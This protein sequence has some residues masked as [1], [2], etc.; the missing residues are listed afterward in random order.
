MYGR[1]VN[2]SYVH[3]YI[4]LFYFTIHLILTEARSKCRVLPLV[5]IVK[6][7]T[8]SLLLTSGDEYIFLKI[9]PPTFISMSRVP[10]PLALFAILYIPH[11]NKEP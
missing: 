10:H 9:T 7:F 4:F 3:I 6:S 8:K 5:F 11:F 1:S 2:T